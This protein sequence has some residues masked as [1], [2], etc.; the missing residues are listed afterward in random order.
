MER[1]WESLG[2]PFLLPNINQPVDAFL[3]ARAVLTRWDMLLS[4]IAHEILVLGCWEE[5]SV[6]FAPFEKTN[7]P[8][9]K[10]P[11]NISV[12]QPSLIKI[13]QKA[14]FSTPKG[15]FSCKV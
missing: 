8:Y 14:V 2:R 7:L 4:F 12:F 5:C 9:H 13:D 3:V 11:F 10:T 15:S 6:L 1:W